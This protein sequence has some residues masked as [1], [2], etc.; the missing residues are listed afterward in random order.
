[1]PAFGAGELRTLLVFEN[2]ANADGSQGRGAIGGIVEDWQELCQRRVSL[3]GIRAAE[4]FELYQRYPEASYGMVL[5][6]DSRAAT[7]TSKTRARNASTG[8]VFTLLGPAQDMD[9]KRQWLQ[10]AAKETAV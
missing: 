1:M 8:Q 5:R 7:I 9:G 10:I 2:D 3:K 6:Y 4:F